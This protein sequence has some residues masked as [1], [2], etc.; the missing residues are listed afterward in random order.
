MN[1]KCLERQTCTHSFSFSLCVFKQTALWNV[2]SGVGCLLYL[3]SGPDARLPEA[4]L[5]HPA[6]LVILF[7]PEDAE[8]SVSAENR[9]YP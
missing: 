1:H 4:S 5:L 7:Q 2:Q 9:Q 3:H 6:A 8:E